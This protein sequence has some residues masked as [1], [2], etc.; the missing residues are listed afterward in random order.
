M[1]ERRHFRAP[2]RQEVILRCERRGIHYKT[3]TRD[4]S[5]GGMCVTGRH[6]MRQANNLNLSVWVRD[7]YLQIPSCVV[8][9]GPDCVGLSFQPLNSLN[10]AALSMLISPCWDGR[11][12]LDG[13]IRLGQ[14]LQMHDLRD[15]MITTTLLQTELRKVCRTRGL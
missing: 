11:D 4:I 3:V 12:M 5:L 1:I 14:V 13:V 6:C 8:W 15:C 9:A 10:E 7:R 2:C